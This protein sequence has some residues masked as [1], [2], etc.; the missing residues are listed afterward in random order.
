MLKPCKK[1]NRSL[2]RDYGFFWAQ[3]FLL[4]AV[5]NLFYQ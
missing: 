3:I 2:I 4:M 1:A 5:V